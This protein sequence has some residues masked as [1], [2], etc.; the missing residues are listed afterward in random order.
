MFIRNHHYYL[1]IDNSKLF[2]LNLIRFR[3]KFSIIYRNNDKPEDIADLKE[4]KKSC[5]RKGVKLFIAN[6]LKLLNKLQADGL[7]LS[8]FN[9]NY[10]LIDKNKYE[11]IGSAHNIKEIFEKKKQGCKTI[12]LSRL[13]RTNYKN[14][15]S[16][17]GVV[18]F[19]LITSLTKSLYVALGGIR[20]ENI[21]TVKMLKS[22][23]IALL[24]EIK[25]K[26]AKIIN[27][28]F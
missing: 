2:N 27:R 4:L 17:F 11:L 9:K 16:F 12:I 14:K 15:K 5:R 28:L 20:L 13:F 23:R 10:L 3:N 21:T 1:Y 7:Y 18:K 8:S 22:D 26:P 19:N 25:K 24:T 6:N